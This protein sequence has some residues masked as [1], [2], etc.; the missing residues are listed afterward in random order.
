[1]NFD[2]EYTI[3]LLLTLFFT[4]WPL[5]LKEISLNIHENSRYCLFVVTCEG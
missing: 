5:A 3:Y 2:Q 4:F 1:M